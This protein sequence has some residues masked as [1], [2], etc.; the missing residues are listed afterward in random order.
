MY[1]SPRNAWWQPSPRRV[2]PRAMCISSV[3]AAV[4]PGSVYARL[5]SVYA[6][7][8]TYTLE[9]KLSNQQGDSKLPVLNWKVLVWWMKI[10]VLRELFPAN[11]SVRLLSACYL[12][13]SMLLGNK[14]YFPI[15]KD[16][17]KILSC[18]LWLCVIV[19]FALQSHK[20]TIK[21]CQ[22]LI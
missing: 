19:V 21:C 13:V 5:G 11:V 7:L 20:T 10:P 8:E 18:D 4:S 12:Q 6:G 16:A 17:W 22:E 15:I 9:K 3:Y 1:N 14:L 2:T